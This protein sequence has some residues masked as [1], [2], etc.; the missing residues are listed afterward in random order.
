MTLWLYLSRWMYS[1]LYL[2]IPDFQHGFMAAAVAL[3]C[4]ADL[5]LGAGK[6]Q[7]AVTPHTVY[8][9]EKP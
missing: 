5:I 9:R 1:G 4:L 8:P 7:P 2:T 6:D 3:A